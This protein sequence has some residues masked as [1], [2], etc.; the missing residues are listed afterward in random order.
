MYNSIPSVDANIEPN[1]ISQLEMSGV[2]WHFVPLLD[3]KHWEEHG[4]T[5]AHQVD[6][7]T[8]E[9]IAMLCVYEKAGWKVWID[10]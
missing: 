10:H 7:C 5:R 4:Y 1:S 6:S 3:L 8:C 2:R 9:G